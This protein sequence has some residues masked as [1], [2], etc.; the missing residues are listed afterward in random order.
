MHI[1]YLQHIISHVLSVNNHM[2]LEDTRLDCAAL[3][4]KIFSFP[5]FQSNQTNP[6]SPTLTDLR[7]S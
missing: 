4:T 2:W 6:T 1:L 7:M 5:A 3:D